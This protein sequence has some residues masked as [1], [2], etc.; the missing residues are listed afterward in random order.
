M[1]KV[2]VPYNI[3][4]CDLQPSIN[5]S[6]VQT[7]EICTPVKDRSSGTV[8]PDDDLLLFPDEAEFLPVPQCKDGR[9]FVLKFKGSE[10][11]LFFWMQEPEKNKDKDK[12]LMEKVSTLFTFFRHLR[13][14]YSEGPFCS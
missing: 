14:I 6:L 11:R 5:S 8:A 1:S 7:S 4:P 12:D 9:V 10:K 2:A 3:G 13:F